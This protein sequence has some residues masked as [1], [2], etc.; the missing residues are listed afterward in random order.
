MEKEIQIE[1]LLKEKDMR[2]FLFRHMY[3]RFSGIFGIILSLL[4]AAVLIVN[5]SAFNTIERIAFGVLALLFTVIQP[6]Q[7]YKKAKNQFRKQESFGKPF[8]Y[9]INSAGIEISQDDQKEQFEWNQVRR[10]VETKS[11]FYVY[12]TSISAFIFPKD[13]CSERYDEIKSVVKENTRKTR[14]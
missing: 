12:M 5:F 2:N 9:V 13:Q 11:A 4:A 7:L 10:T 3:T 8:R 14:G 6:W 1:V